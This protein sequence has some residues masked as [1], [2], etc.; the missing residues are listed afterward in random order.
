MIGKTHHILPGGIPDCMVAVFI[1]PGPILVHPNISKVY[2]VI[3][4]RS[5]TF[6]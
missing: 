3:G 4:L 6:T 5:V 1:G 2:A